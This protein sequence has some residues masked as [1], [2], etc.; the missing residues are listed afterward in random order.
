MVVAAADLCGSKASS[1]YR[2]DD[3]L[4]CICGCNAGECGA[5]RAKYAKYAG[6]AGECRAM[7]AKC[8]GCYF[9]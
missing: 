3:R 8:A 1:I 7:Q 9:R 4:P 2:E 6:D 5:M